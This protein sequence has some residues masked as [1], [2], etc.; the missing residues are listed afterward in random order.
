MDHSITGN[1]APD[2]VTRVENFFHKLERETAEG[3][4]A[5][6]SEKYAEHFVAA[7]P[8]GAK[9]APRT[10]FVE[11]MPQRKEVFDKL[12][13]KP[14]RLI[15]LETTALDTRYSLAKGRWLLEFARDGQPPQEVL[16]DSTYVIDTGEEPYRIILYLTSQDLP[17]VLVERGILPG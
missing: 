10:V 14:P 9:I 7:S 3:D 16:A 2:I 13:A 1:S 17:K 4:F 5:A 11:S 12:G 8:S 15:S 6:L